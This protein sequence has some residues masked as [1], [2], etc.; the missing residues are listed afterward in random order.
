[1]PPIQPIPRTS[2]L[3][4]RIRIR[5][6]LLLAR[7][8]TRRLI[9]N[10]RSGWDRLT[11]GLQM[12]ELWAQFK[13]EARESSLLYRM[14]LGAEKP[15]PR[16][17]WTYPFKIFNALFWSVVRKL[18]PARRI[19]LLATI[20]LAVVAVLGFHFLF[21]TPSIEFLVAF[22][23]LLLLLALVLGDHVSMKRDLEIAREIQRW[24]VPHKAPA[25]GG[26]DI[27]FATQPAKTVGGDYYDAFLRSE[28]GPLLVVVADVSGKG[29]PAAMLM[30]TFQAS[31]RA[32]AAS[33][34]SLADLARDL[35]R[36]VCATSPNGR[37]TTAFLAELDPLSGELRYVC[38]GHNPPMV[39]RSTGECELL[40]STSLP[41]GIELREDYAS[42][43]AHLDPLDLLLI[44]TDGVTD[45]RNEYGAEFGEE[46]LITLL[47]NAQ[48]ED[49]SQL[50]NH[51]TGE[52][53][54]FVG[55]APQ[56]DDLTCLLLR[57]E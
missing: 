40:A 30:A 23:G 3:S 8:R 47:Q 54:A 48:G 19:F 35:N 10:S 43:V 16:R 7:D 49:V 36:Q 38:A 27:A 24:L 53:G 31:L 1:M 29:V 50:L 5:Q 20:V 22:T 12:E 17:T 9:V 15:L 32:L 39:K 25:V 26:V 44:Y 45:A 18:S 34:S 13:S 51:I 6:S 56:H 37:F 55:A 41:L 2:S 4:G 46:N 52:I 28:N 42:S 11:A 14:D 33:P 57:R 21:F